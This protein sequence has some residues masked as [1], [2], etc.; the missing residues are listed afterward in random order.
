MTTQNANYDPAKDGID[1]I[2]M[3]TKG[4]TLLGRLLTNLAATPF[5]AADGSFQCIE[6]YWYWLGITN[7]DREQLRN[8]NG[9]ES[10]ALGKTLRNSAA[11]IP[12]PKF[13]EKI[14]MALIAKLKANPQIAELLCKS[15]LPLAHYYV[16]AMGKAIPQDKFNWLTLIWESLRKQLQ[17]G[18][19]VYNLVMPNMGSTENPL[20]VKVLSPAAIAKKPT[21]FQ[22]LLK[23]KQA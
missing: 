10:K 16:S 1:H 5:S 12:D 20:G 14:G 6:G 4:K 19:P 7:A 2:N 3:Y 18:K 17:E 9:F 23:M 13:K 21:A 15:T 11:S 22:L 8:T